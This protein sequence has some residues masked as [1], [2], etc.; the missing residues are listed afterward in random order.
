ML[1]RVFRGVFPAASLKQ[2][3][4]LRGSVMSPSFPRGI[5]RGLIEAW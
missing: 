1:V 4:L 3:V 2:F 5:P